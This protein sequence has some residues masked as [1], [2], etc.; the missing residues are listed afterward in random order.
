M[1]QLFH[2]ILINSYDLGVILKLKEEKNLK[3]SDI[4]YRI[5]K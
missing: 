3:K 5:R 1:L 2:L 4:P